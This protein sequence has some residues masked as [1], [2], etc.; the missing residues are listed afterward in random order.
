ME[1][2]NNQEVIQNNETDDSSLQCTSV[3]D[4]IEKYENGTIFSSAEEEKSEQFDESAS[5]PNINSDTSSSTSAVPPTTTASETSSI[6]SETTSNS[7][8]IDI[9]CKDS[10]VLSTNIVSDSNETVEAKETLAELESLKDS[11]IHL[12]DSSVEEESNKAVSAS[13]LILSSLENKFEDENSDNSSFSTNLEIAADDSTVIDPVLCVNSD[14]L[15]M[16]ENILQATD[17]TSSIN[18][19]MSIDS[20]DNNVL[21]TQTD[22]IPDL[23]EN[24]DNDV[25]K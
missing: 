14:S 25:K 13:K 21:E 18:A 22:T 17:E 16:K 15:T 3:K 8:T 19:S 6:N 2:E 12:P 20:Y 1:E 23:Q 7:T 24:V 10:C 9:L 5:T 11:I 4:L